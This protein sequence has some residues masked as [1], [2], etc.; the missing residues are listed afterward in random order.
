MLG[1]GPC[2]HMVNVLA[3]LSLAEGWARALAGQANWGELFEGFNSAVDYPAA[4]FYRELLAAYPDAKVV[5]SVRDGRA[6]ARSMH[7]TIWGVQYDED[8]IAYHLAAARGCI[9][10]TM[11]TYTD[12]MMT[13]LNMAGLFGPTPAR[14]NEDALAAGME[15]H[16]A[17]VRA[18]VPAHRLLE[19]S[20]AD[21]W[22]PLCEF[23]ERP[24]PAAPL[25]CVN[26]TATFNAAVVAGAMEKL[27]DWWFQR[28]APADRPDVTLPSQAGAARPC[29]RPLRVINRLLIVCTSVRLFAASRRHR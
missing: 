7:D 16:N 8:S 14:F 27:N 25:P 3:D 2:Y 5:L 4:F 12:L 19:W 6:W 23:L 21:G 10:P 1:F 24:V 26:D 22:G 20:P 17:A 28:P 15:R 11:R 18:R 13:M 9:D 29:C